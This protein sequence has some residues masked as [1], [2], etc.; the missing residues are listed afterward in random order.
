M[1]LSAAQEA[2]FSVFVVVGL[3]LFGRDGW[4]GHLVPYVGYVAD[5]YGEQKRYPGHGG[6]GKLARGGVGD[7]ERALGM[8]GGGEEGGVV[9]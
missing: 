2:G 7:E 8:G 4:I 3:H 6:E 1:A 9:V 5:D